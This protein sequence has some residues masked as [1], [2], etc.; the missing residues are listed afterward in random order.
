MSLANHDAKYADLY[1][2]TLYNAIL[3]DLDLDGKNFTYTN[4]L[5]TGPRG[6]ARYLWHNRPC[7]VGNIPRTLL[8][9]PTWMYTRNADSMDVN[10]F[11]GSTVTIQNIAGGDVQM[12]QT[13]DYPWS[14]KVSITVNPSAARTFTIRVRVPDRHVSALYTAT[15][16][17]DGITTIAVNG[18][19]ITPTIEQGYATIART[20]NPGDTIEMVL[21]MTVQR[22]KADPRVAADQGRVALRYGPLIYNLEAVDQPN[23]DLPV[24][25]DAA[26]TA[27]WQ[28]DLLGGVMAIKGT[29]ADGSPMTAIPN[30]ARCN[31]G[32]RSLVWMKDQ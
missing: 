18:A 17:S 14:N 25:S 26:L 32:G 16:D 24:K 12:V 3:G 7:C 22:I 19:A 27:V 20:W 31:R 29:F 1:E 15:P 13:T 28:P 2:D 6:G 10:L 11:I 8:Q 23:L 5:D 21:P 9:L 30:Y 4:P